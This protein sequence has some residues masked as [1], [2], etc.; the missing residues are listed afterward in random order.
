MARARLWSSCSSNLPDFEAKPLPYYAKCVVVVSL[1]INSSNGR[2]LLFRAGSPSP[3]SASR[4]ASF[5]SHS[6]FRFVLKALYKPHS[7]R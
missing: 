3:N 5:S 2:S 7:F 6:P 4:A 1:H